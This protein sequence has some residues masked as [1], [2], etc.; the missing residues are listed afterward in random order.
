VR[1]VYYNLVITGLSIAA[2]FVIGS[3]ELLGVLTGELHLHGAFWDVVTNFNINVAGFVIAGLFVVIWVV[4]IAYWSSA[5]SSA[6]GK[7]GFR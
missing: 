1:K 6:A 5:R 7:A 2:A 3:I 4:A